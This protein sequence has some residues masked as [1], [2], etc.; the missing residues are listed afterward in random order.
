MY[1]ELFDVDQG[2]QETNWVDSL[3]LYELTLIKEN[4]DHN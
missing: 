4:L 2:E 3:D 1:Q